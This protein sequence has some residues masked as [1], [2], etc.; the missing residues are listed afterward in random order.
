MDENRNI[1][2]IDENLQ[3]SEAKAKAEAAS[4]ARAE[5]KAEEACS[6]TSEAQKAAQGAQGAQTAQ[7]TQNAQKGAFPPPPP[8]PYQNRGNGAYPPPRNPQNPYGAPQGAGTYAPPR[9]PYGAP[10]TPYNPYAQ[11]TYQSMSFPMQ[12]KKKP[13]WLFVLLGVLGFLFFVGVIAAI[14]FAAVSSDSK[15]GVPSLS[16][17]YVAVLTIDSEI[18]GDY[19][20]TKT[21]GSYSSY[22]QVYLIDT[23]YELA[24]DELN[25]G[26]MLYIDSPGGEVIATDELG[27][28]IEYYKT[29]TNRPVYAYF[30]SVAAS[31]AYWLGSYADKII[32]H[33]YCTTGSIGVTYGAHMEIS[34][35]LEKLGIKVTMITSG[36][37]KAMGSMYEPLT[38]EQ[39]RILQEQID[40]MYDDFVNLVAENRNIPVAEVK[41]IADGRTMLA[42][43]ALSYKLID[44][45]GYYSDAKATMIADCGLDENIVFYEC[46]NPSYTQTLSLTSLLQAEENEGLT[47]EEALD[48]LIKEIFE[49]RKF[50]VIYEK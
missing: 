17:K 39:E 37:N 20:Y 3:S 38:E 24:A 30:S 35:L 10:Y 22:N 14:T 23:I 36:D 40:E 11:P 12:K 7:S 21:Y 9:P 47:E 13:T 31:G 29:E 28:T 25:A 46:Q 2:N 18:A 5:A 16:E 32:A 45:I 19:Q 49:N 41:K 48:A 6:D 34:E 15:S 44:G 1:D 4:E 8:P 50:M 42:S 26:L 43:K 33:K 27:K